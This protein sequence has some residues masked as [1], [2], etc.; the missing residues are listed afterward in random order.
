MGDSSSHR[1]RGRERE[2]EDTY[3]DPHR[4][5]HRHRHTHT[6]SDTHTHTQTHTLRHTDTDS[7]TQTQTHR[8]TQTQTQT[9]TFPPAPLEPGCAGSD[10]YGVHDISGLLKLYFRELPEALIPPTLRANLFMAIELETHEEKLVAIKEVLQYFP[11]TH[12]ETFK[13]CWESAHD[14]S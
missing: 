12:Y 9:H 10:K 6:H 4:H 14:F 3:T 7:H 8:K 13:V 11:P 1:E 5:R 2:R